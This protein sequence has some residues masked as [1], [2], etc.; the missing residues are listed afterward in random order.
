M[1]RR[2]GARN[3]RGLEVAGVVL[4]SGSIISK[5][6]LCAGRFTKRELA[7]DGDGGVGHQGEDR[8]PKSVDEHGWKDED[9]ERIRGSFI[10]ELSPLGWAA[11][12]R[13]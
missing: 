1:Y 10:R 8:K 9:V 4:G 2:S 11:N 6:G 13:Y 3:A 12:M 7:V 5:R